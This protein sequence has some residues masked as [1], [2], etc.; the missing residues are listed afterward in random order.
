[1]SLLFSSFLAGIILFLIYTRL[2]QYLGPV[3]AGQYGLLFAYL[4]VLNFFVDLGM[5]QLVIKKISEDKTH[6]SKYLSNYFV[7]QF[8][9]GLIFMVIMDSIVLLNDYPLMVKAALLITSVSLLVSSLALPFRAVITAN[10]KLTI[11]A[12]VNFVN[13]IINGLMMVLAIILH[14]NV[15][16]LSFISVTVSAFDL[17]VYW[18]IVHRKFTRFVFE[19]D[20]KF[21]RQLFI[22]NL[23]FTLLTFFSIYN[24]IDSLLLPHLRNFQEAGYYATA[25]KF[26]DTLAFLPGVIGIALFPFFAE[27]LSKNLKDEVRSGLETYSR[28]MIALGLPLA[29]GSFLVAKPLT[30]AL[31]GPDFLP[32][33]S[34]LWLLVGAVAVLFIYSPVN[35]LI[36]SQ[37][38][39]IATTITGFNLLFNIIA[40][41]V[42]IP[43][44]GFV[45]AAVITLISELIQ[46]IGYTYFVKK[47]VVDFKFFRHFVKPIFATI[48]MAGVVWLFRGYSVWLVMALA[49]VTYGI[50]LVLLRFFHREDWELFKAAANVKKDLNPETIS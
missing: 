24:R 18:I 42:F 34:A 46:A 25:Y 39:R 32:A 27:R 1:L 23:P 20:G 48:I 33:A 49:G 21:I 28:Y 36:I 50:S 43:K 14:K 30:L 10:Q 11:I 17:V 45:A 22:W 47:R 19:I 26:W 4:T 13:S 2:V 7:V 37:L 9:L 44:F 6:T 38:T 12:K 41:L 35:S 5:S 8:G 15:F 3:A 40:N 29:V 16:Y 31:F